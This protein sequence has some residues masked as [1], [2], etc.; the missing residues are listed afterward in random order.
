LVQQV[1]AKAAELKAS[2][3]RGR[4]PGRGH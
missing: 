3:P 4:R 2:D 1:E